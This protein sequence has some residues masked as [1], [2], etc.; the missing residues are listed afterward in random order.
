MGDQ[1][2]VNFEQIIPMKDAEE[3]SI[4]MAEKTQEDISSQAELKTRHLIRREFW[5]KL[6]KTANEKSQL[7]QN[8]S[9]STSSWIGAGSGVRGM[10]YNYVISKKYAR[11]EIYIDRGEYDENKK[12]FDYLVAKREEIETEFGGSLEWERLDDKRASR[13]KYE[14]SDFNIFEK[15]QWDDIVGFLSDGMT[16]MEKAFQKHLNHIQKN[17]VKH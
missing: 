8:I 13:I 3:Y 14:N 5:T 12:M 7:F 10:G 9:P 2:L 6:L 1:L 15:E 17:M 11:C 4:S 16:R